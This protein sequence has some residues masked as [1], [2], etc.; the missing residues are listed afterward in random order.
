M[1]LKIFQ[2]KYPGKRLQNNLSILNN[3]KK[4]HLIG[5]GGIGMFGIADFLI[6]QGYKVSGSDIH[7]SKLTDELKSRGAEIF[8]GHK[9]EN[10]SDDV[11]LV[12]YSSAVKKDN[13]EYIAASKIKLIRRA[14]MLGEIVNPRK[15]IS[16]S[17]THGKTTVSAM[18]SF[19]LTENNF[20]PLVFVGGNLNFLG[21][22]ASRF[23]SG[24]Y[25][26]AEAD[27][28][29]RSF[30]ALKSDILVINNVELDHTDIY[31][32]DDDIK[33]AFLEFCHNSKEGCK[34]IFNLDD[35]GAE[36]VASKVEYRH[37]IS[38]GMNS[39]SDYL[40]SEIN[41]GEEFTEFYLNDIKIAIKLHGEHN[42]YNAAAALIASVY[43]GVDIENILLSLA[44]FTTVK[45]RLELKYNVNIRVYDD[46]A[47]HPTE[48]KKSL[49]A[50][51]EI[52]KGRIITVF[53]PHTYS[54][55]ERFSKEFAESLSNS[56]IIFITDIYPAR[57]EP[58][59]GVNSEL[60]VNQIKSTNNNVYYEKESSNLINALLSIINKNDTV[61]FQGAGDITNICDDFVK[62]IKEIS[63]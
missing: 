31:S 18:I 55:T 63:L 5:I 20:D 44:K 14:E 40:L 9:K 52:N 21:N 6:A 45:R 48:I 49:D 33:K 23:G 34:I 47:H 60:I 25:A 62:N 41:Y 17:G 59:K 57:E 61:L 22:K 4:V 56:D 1:N 38:F 51:R 39:S 35:F 2:K 15:L 11:N 29:E 27:E 19:I 28:Y 24:E 43:A 8:I 54:R 53:Q 32:S 36:E 10:I 7:R 50:L 58:I 3:V 30:L 26:V 16:V 12:V 37:L 42:V 46:Y 13:P